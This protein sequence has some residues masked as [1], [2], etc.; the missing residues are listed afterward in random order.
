VFLLSR[1]FSTACETPVNFVVLADELDRDALQFVVNQ[2][3]NAKLTGMQ[4]VLGMSHHPLVL[5]G[6]CV[7]CQPLNFA[8]DVLT[9]FLRDA[10]EVFARTVREDDLIGGFLPANSRSISSHV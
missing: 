3:E 9:V 7:P 10:F 5:Y 2:V 4:A 8:Q 1:V 6:R